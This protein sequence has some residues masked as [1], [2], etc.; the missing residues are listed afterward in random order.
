MRDDRIIKKNNRTNS[1]EKVREND[2]SR[3]SSTNER[4]SKLN[5]TP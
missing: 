1:R 5:R 2:D 4:K 3:V